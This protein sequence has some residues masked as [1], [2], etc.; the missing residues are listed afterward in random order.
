M[1]YARDSRD[2]GTYLTREAG[3]WIGAGIEYAYDAFFG[4]VKA[5]LHWS[6]I[7]PDVN[8]GIGFYIS[9]GYNF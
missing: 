1:N 9:I 5:D 6:N 4:P 2:F 7:N 8:G 3:N